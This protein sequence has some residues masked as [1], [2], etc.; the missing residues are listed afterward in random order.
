MCGEWSRAR[1]YAGLAREARERERLRQ[2]EGRTAFSRAQIQATGTGA[3]ANLQLIN[4]GVLAPG[5]SMFG[6][7]V[8]QPLSLLSGGPGTQ[9]QWGNQSPQLSRPASPPAPRS[10]LLGE[11]CCFFRSSRW[12]F[13]KE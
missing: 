9:T 3:G 2:E 4:P 12:L 10:Q 13:S 6:V 8:T 11:V 7:N 1:D 5:R